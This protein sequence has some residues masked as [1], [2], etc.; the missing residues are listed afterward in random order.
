MYR[1]FNI[2]LES[3]I[4]LPELAELPVNLEL[5]RFTF[6]LFPAEES[7]VANIDWFHDWFDPNGDINISAGRCNNAYWLRFPGMVDF[8]L[9]LG[10]RS[11]TGY[12]YPGTPE[13]TARHMLLDQV[14]PRMLGQLE[15]LILHAGAVT[16]SNGKTVAFIGQSGWG[17]STLVSSFQQHGAK[18]ITDDCLMIVLEDGQISAIPN[19]YGIRLFDDSIN[20]IYGQQQEAGDVAHYTSKRRLVMPDNDQDRAAASLQLDAIFLLSDPEVAN[21]DGEISITTAGGMDAMMTLVAQTFVLDVTEK[22]LMAIQ[23]SNCGKILDSELLCFRID[24]PRDHGR[25]AEVRKAIETVLDN[26]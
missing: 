5:E 14:I 23:F 6:S 12:Q 19:Y 1:I 11:I 20:A 10:N 25:L 17:K 2:A 3:S 7:E 24:F 22:Q 8:E 16:L 9:H 18:L 4:A 13:S 26:K 15:H 21:T